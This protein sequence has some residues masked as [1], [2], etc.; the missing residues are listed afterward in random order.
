[1]KWELSY[2]ANAK[3]GYKKLKNQELLVDRLG[4]YLKILQD[5]PFSGEYEKLQNPP[6]CYS[7][8]LNGQHRLCYMVNVKKH[9]VI[10]SSMWGH[11]ND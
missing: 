5:N 4:D 6:N 10:V 7:R 11:Y 2:T 3:K 9:K 8:R 1:M